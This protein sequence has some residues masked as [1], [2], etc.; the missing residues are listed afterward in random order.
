MGLSTSRISK[1]EERA[2]RLARFFDALLESA[3]A[4]GLID[5]KGKVLSQKGNND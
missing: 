4:N 5:K 1:D 2:E 3:L